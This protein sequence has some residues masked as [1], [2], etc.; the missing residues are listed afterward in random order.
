MWWLLLVAGATLAGIGLAATIPLMRRRVPDPP[1]NPILHGLVCSD[2]TFNSR[3][4]LRLGGWW[5]PAL[6]VPKGTVVLCPGQNGSMDKDVPQ[7]VPLVRAGFSVLMFDFRGH[8]RSA[9]RLVTLGG[10]EP[11]DLRGA[12][13]YLES[14]HGVKRAG[15]LGFSMGAGVTLLTAAQDERIAALVVDGAYPR[16][17]GILVAWCRLKG[18]P[19]PLDRG[20]A[21]LALLAGSIRA[22]CRLNRANPIRTAHQITAPALL[23]HGECDPFASVAEV[24][25]L[26]ARLSGPAEVWT[27]VGAGH[28]QAF[29]N[30]PDEYNTRLVEWFTRYL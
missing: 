29:R 6:G 26:A 5:I 15:V 28:R 24:K 19:Q 16:L 14:A 7:A 9:G 22:R 25:A 17:S 11:A 3:D 2:V 27:V 1:D 12:L 10:Q 18:I 20:L 13:D 4:G 21:W 8:G 23:I 30:Q